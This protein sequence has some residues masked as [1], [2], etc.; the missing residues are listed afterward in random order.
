MGSSFAGRRPSSPALWRTFRLRRAARHPARRRAQ[1]SGY[2]VFSAAAVERIRMTKALQ[3]LAFTLDEVIDALT[4]HMTK[5]GPPATARD[6][7]WRR[8]WTYRYQDR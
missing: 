2:R 5:A 8:W 6:G 7:D 4:T 3:E 1:T